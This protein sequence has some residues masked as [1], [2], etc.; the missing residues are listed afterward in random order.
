MSIS[1]FEG[2]FKGYN[3]DERDKAQLAL[4]KQQIQLQSDIKKA[5]RDD[6]ISEALEIFRGQKEILKELGFGPKS[7]TEKIIEK[8][9]IQKELKIGPY[10]EKSFNIVLP[11]DTSNNLP[12][13]TI[14]FPIASELY[15]T[16]YNKGDNRQ[17]KLLSLASQIEN[18]KDYEAFQKAAIGHGYSSDFINETRGYVLKDAK[19][20]Y[21]DLTNAMQPGL[22]LVH[23]INE[24]SPFY[25]GYVSPYAIARLGLDPS[26]L[27]NSEKVFYVTPN[28][29]DNTLFDISLEKPEVEEY[30][31]FKYNNAKDLLDP[32]LSLSSVFKSDGSH[33][34]EGIGI[35]PTNMDQMH[36]IDMAYFDA[37]IAEN[38]NKILSTFDRYLTTD[39][40]ITLYDS[41]G[42]AIESKIGT[43]LKKQELSDALYKLSLDPQFGLT[44][45]P[46]ILE[47]KN[48]NRNDEVYKTNMKKLD[49][50]SAQEENI[51]QILDIMLTVEG[52]IDALGF[53]GTINKNVENLLGPEGQLTQLLAIGKQAFDRDKEELI[54]E[55]FKGVNIV[56]RAYSLVFDKEAKARER[57]DALYT[58]LA[59]NVALQIQGGDSLSAR[60]SNE[61]FNNSLRVVSGGAATPERTRIKILLDYLNR[62][63]DKR[64]TLDLLRNNRGYNFSSTYDIVRPYISK[65]INRNLVG[66]GSDDVALSDTNPVRLI[67]AYSLIDDKK[68][69]LISKVIN[70]AYA[71]DFSDLYT[72]DTIENA[73]EI[74]NRFKTE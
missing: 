43:G 18:D 71:D 16:G 32:N 5:G 46:I 51:F 45:D 64:V 23:N 17:Q 21:N 56:E 39:M 9:A 26:Q 60:I 62:G 52:G 55:G 19:G 61:D 65:V 7:E 66:Q 27:K 53:A 38:E 73:E 72:Q 57:L 37:G 6:R 33:Y 15:G 54:A 58:V 47:N 44:G 30:Q 49:Q 40:D 63:I 1:L 42:S 11:A 4:M 14:S 31:V 34:R 20:K 10:A 22:Q 29:N 69:K 8:D 59:Y 2:L 28:K 67:T 68:A 70:A 12:E 50:L 74:V 36:I 3:Q 13:R 41:Q 48:L 24:N 25:S 35:D